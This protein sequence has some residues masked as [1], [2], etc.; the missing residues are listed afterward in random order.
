VTTALPVRP[1]PTPARYRTRVPD[2]AAV[3][4]WDELCDHLVVEDRPTGEV[5]GTYR[6]LPPERARAIGR[7]YGDAEF[8]LSR[9]AALRPTTAEAGRSWVH[10]D[11]RTGAVITALWAGI[12]RYVLER[13]L[14]H[15]AGCTS[16]PVADGGATAAAV[17]D[18]VRPGYLAPAAR[19]WCRTC[20]STS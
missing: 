19:G 11:H 5:V 3:D 17:W 18:V 10:P 15:L 16:V 9:H 14:T 4:E 13:G 1:V 12:A 7:T 6:L 8:D 2:P 20:R